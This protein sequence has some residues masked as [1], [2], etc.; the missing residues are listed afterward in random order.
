MKHYDANGN[1][2]NCGF[3]QYSEQ[4]DESLT[5]EAGAKLDWIRDRE[6]KFFKTEEGQRMFNLLEQ[7][8]QHNEKIDPL[9]P[10][11]WREAKK[12]RFDDTPRGVDSLSHMADWFESN[13]PTR[14]GVDIMQLTW[15]DVTAKVAEWDE[16]LQGKDAD[17]EKAGGEI[18]HDF[19]DGWTIRKLTTAEEAKVEGDAMGHCVG[20]YGSA[21]ESN[22][23][24]IF[25]LRDPQNQPHVTIELD[26]WGGNIVQIQGKGNKTPIPEYQER[27]GNWLLSKDNPPAVKLYYAVER[28]YSPRTVSDLW[29]YMNLEDGYLETME[30]AVEPTSWKDFFNPRDE[31]G[32]TRG[33]TQFNP[34]MPG[35]EGYDEICEYPEGIDIQPIEV[36]DLLAIAADAFDWED[37]PEAMETL[38]EIL[39]DN[40]S[41]MIL[42]EDQVNKIRT[43]IYSL[44]LKY[45]KIIDGYL[46]DYPTR[47]EAWGN[48]P[49]SHA[50][51][52]VLGYSFIDPQTDEPV[53]SY[54]PPAPPNPNQN[55]LFFA[56]R[57]DY[58]ETE[59][60]TP[61]PWNDSENPD[62]QAGKFSKL[63]ARLRRSKKANILDEVHG[64][65][66]PSV[67][68]NAASPMPALKEELAEW[69]PQFITEALERNGYTDMGDWLSF[70][71]TGSLTT[72][73]YSDR[74]DCDISLFVNAEMFPEWSRAEMIAIMMDE[75]DGTFVPGTRHELQCYVV[76]SEFTRED[77]YKPG[78][79]SAY[80]IMERR[81]IVP[82]EK[83][84]SHNVKSEM[85]EAYTIAL[86]N[87]DKMEKLI[88]YEPLKA[89]KYY[90]QVHRRRRRD[91]QAGA[92]DFSPSNISYKMMEER[93]LFDRV[94]SLM[95]E[96]E[97]A[98]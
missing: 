82:P 80:D 42:S 62:N 12:N 33:R 74:S 57:R 5:K 61:I 89:I 94:H 51:D 84:R 45:F 87:A 15:D 38:A 92:G 58:G 95:K 85:N 7:L 36:E 77:L 41:H 96:Y 54:I 81:W 10:W 24:S 76:P 78:M 49:F 35:D 29:S 59:E 26:P 13:S 20:G 40:Q 73:Q 91:M 44:T 19:G 39:E 6:D 1:V 46:G 68:K 63:I 43:I 16:E 66:D 98:Y 93:G 65:L 75:C 69:I 56:P 28:F 60:P 34:L 18:V 22:R 14:R 52:R 2:C 72:Y 48:Y 17:L 83:D 90:E 32:S 71:L 27:V 64:Y 31:N 8:V 11:L 50:I 4:V 88:R 3:G 21:I 25:S 67:W 70:V 53:G 9:V 37:G 47:Y 97:S 79:R 86:E 30:T 55:E 23:T